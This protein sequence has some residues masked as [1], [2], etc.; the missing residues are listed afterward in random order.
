MTQCWEWIKLVNCSVY[1]FY[2]IWTAMVMVIVTHIIVA[3]CNTVNTIITIQQ[4]FKVELCIL[5]DYVHFL[6]SVFGCNTIREIEYCISPKGGWGWIQTGQIWCI[7][8]T[9][10]VH[11]LWR[12]QAMIHYSP[13][14]IPVSPRFLGI[15]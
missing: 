12:I 7:Q 10:V 13:L 5:C 11:S 15:L 9:L 1:I 6:K 3:Y 8:T 4:N 14:S 2:V